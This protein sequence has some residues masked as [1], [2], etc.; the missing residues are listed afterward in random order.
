MA[1]FKLEN[2][3]SGLSLEQQKDEMVEPQLLA[4]RSDGSVAKNRLGFLDGLRGISALS[5]VCF[6]ATHC[7][8]YGKPAGLWRIPQ[9][10]TSF[11]PLAVPFFLALSGYGIMLSISRGGNLRVDTRYFG[12]RARRILP[13]YFFALLLSCAALII[14]KQNPKIWDV[15]L[16]AF[17]ISAIVSH[18]ILVHNLSSSSCY[19]LNGP[20]WSVATEWQIY[21]FL[22]LAILPAWR[23]LG[24]LGATLVAASIG[25]AIGAV[26]P[27]ARFHLLA[28]FALGAWAA[29]ASTKDRLAKQFEHGLPTIAT[30]ALAWIL[31]VPLGQH[32]A[33]DLVAGIAAALCILFLKDSRHRRNFESKYLKTLGDM[34]YSLYLAH[35]PLL[36]LL[37]MPAVMR[38]AGPNEV[39][40]VLLLGVLWALSGSYIFHL[41]CERPFLVKTSR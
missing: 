13:A 36:G 23:K 19:K 12:R 5:V 25:L 22:P 18:L 21:F 10:F 33:G 17:S 2:W 27:S 8:Q 24:P 37:V 26:F 6:H 1:N 9:L 35:I 28:V 16:P 39:R 31:Y 29:D 11:G 34:S 15:E 3:F 32:T 20:L 41:V 38:H 14:T 4:G 40:A 30:L 7:S